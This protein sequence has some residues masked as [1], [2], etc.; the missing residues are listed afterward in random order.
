MEDFKTLKQTF[1]KLHW[2]VA[3][4]IILKE[5]RVMAKQAI[6]MHIRKIWNQP[7]FL[8]ST[9]KKNIWF[10]FGRR[11]GNGCMQFLNLLYNLY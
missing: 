10:G 5:A 9:K 7:S 11:L 4:H 8:S 3:P 6:Q 1:H 2:R